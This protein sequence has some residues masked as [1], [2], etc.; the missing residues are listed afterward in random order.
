MEVVA[1][2]LEAIELPSAH[3]PLEHRGGGIE[4]QH[5]VRPVGAHRPL[6]EAP[7]FGQRQFAPVALVGERGVH[8][9]VAHHVAAADERGRNDLVDVLRAVGCSEQRLGAVREVGDRGVVQDGAN[10]LPDGRAT[11]LACE[12]GVERVGEPSRMGALPAPFGA[13]ER[14]VAAGRHIRGTIPSETD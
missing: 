3:A 9:A 12:H 2:L 5:Q 13:L 4:Q 8:A 7:H 10:A 14:D 11:C 1:F 6:V